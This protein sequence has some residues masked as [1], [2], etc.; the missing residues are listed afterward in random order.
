MLLARLGFA[1]LTRFAARL[2]F[3]ALGRFAFLIFVDL[4][5][6]VTRFVDFFFG[7]FF[8]DFDFAAGVRL[9]VLRFAVLRF[10]AFP[11]AIGNPLRNHQVR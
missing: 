8:G 9:A 2:D 5:L 3:A 10:A 11:P 7:D 4:R 1:A 6:A